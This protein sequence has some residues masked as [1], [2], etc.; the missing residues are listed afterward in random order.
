MAAHRRR[1]AVTSLALLFSFWDTRLIFGVAMEIALIA[2]VVMRPEVDPTD[3]CIVRNRPSAIPDCRRSTAEETRMP[4]V[5]IPTSSGAM[6]AYLAVP[7]T[8]GPWP[9]VAIIHDALGMTTDLRH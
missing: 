5:T 2:L 3:Q 4:T 1:A 6:D 9:A 8:D 7:E